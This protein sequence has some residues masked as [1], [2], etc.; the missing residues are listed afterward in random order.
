MTKNPNWVCQHLCK[1]VMS[2][3]GNRKGS[4]EPFAEDPKDPPHMRSTLNDYKGSGFDRG[5]MVAAGDIKFS[6]KALDETFFLSNISPQ[7]GVGFNRG[8]WERLERW[9][10]GLVNKN[11]FSDVF[12]ITGPLYIP[13]KESDGKFYMH[14]QVL[15]NGQGVHVPTHFFKVI[16]ALPARGSQA[17]LT[18]AAAP[19]KGDA[20]AVALVPV[21]RAPDRPIALGAFVMP[22]AVIDDNTPLEKFSIP[23]ELL[24]KT[25]GLE[26]F[27][28]LPRTNGKHVLPLCKST[29]C[30]LPPPF[31]PKR[32]IEPRVFDLKSAN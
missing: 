27:Q 3:S 10:R 17:A 29:K 22:N 24:E 30:Q 26:F 12:V 13:S 19:T 9:C 5:H 18:P 25:S 2:G 4:G 14:H 32:V 11:E 1:E 23:L 31:Q 21:G 28:R 20:D 6:Q 7:V 8:Y 16:M 15:S